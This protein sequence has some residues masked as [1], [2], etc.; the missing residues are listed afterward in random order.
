MEGPGDK[1]YQKILL[2]LAKQCGFSSPF[3]HKL[4]V[5]C[6]FSRLLSKES[7]KRILLYIPCLKLLGGSQTI[8]CA[9]I[10]WWAC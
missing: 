6:G 1:Y 4:L 3:G 7:G 8:V 5:S 2:T 10:T 9:R